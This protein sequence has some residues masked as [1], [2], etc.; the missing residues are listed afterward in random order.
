MAENSPIEHE[1]T[2]ATPCLPA[3]WY[4]V[5][6]LFDETLG[7]W[8]LGRAARPDDRLMFLRFVTPSL[9]EDSQQSLGACSTS[10]TTCSL[11]R[12]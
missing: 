3:A 5:E 7:G 12:I 4:A 2:G 11:T 10:R 1:P 9:D 6:T 8:S